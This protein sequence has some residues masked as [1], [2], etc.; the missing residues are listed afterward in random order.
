MNAELL[1]MFTL[2]CDRAYLFAHPERRLTS[3]EQSRYESALAERCRGVPAQYI[4]G[5]Q[6]FWGMD[7]IVTPAVLIPRPET[8]HVIETVLELQPGVGQQASGK[9]RVSD[10]GLQTSGRVGAE[11]RGPRSEVRTVD[12]GTGSGCIALALAKELPNAEIHATDISPA[13]LEIARA[14][15]ARHQLE[16]RIHFRQADLLEGLDGQFDFVVS[17]PPYVGESEEDTVQL[18]VRK[19]EPRTAV[20]AG[21]KGTE[22]IA[23]LIPQAR[24]ALSPGGWLVMEISG[25]IAEDVRGLLEG[26][27]EVQITADLQSIPRV[28]RAQRPKT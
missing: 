10:L 13:A 3:D 6:E 5:H 18:D 21:P 4:T 19:F 27:D 28:V 17:N 26:W 12:V 24:A 11:A 25:T 23:R 2:G 9:L 8:E 7:L 20:F 1:L 15:A 22:V 14:N 16:R